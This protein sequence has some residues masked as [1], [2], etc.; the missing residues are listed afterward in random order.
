M[1]KWKQNIKVFYHDT[2]I[3]YE[4]LNKR[5]IYNEI[6]YLTSSE[7]AFTSQNPPRWQSGALLESLLSNDSTLLGLAQQAMKS[8][9][10]FWTKEFL[11][12]IQ[13]RENMKERTYTGEVRN[14][15]I[16]EHQLYWRRI[17]VIIEE[18][19]C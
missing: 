14:V 12:N 1:F 17:M 13:K 18:K 10:L 3:S 15:R 4:A 19:A 16:D 9:I 7:L 8:W 6:F 5:K 11:I 2:W